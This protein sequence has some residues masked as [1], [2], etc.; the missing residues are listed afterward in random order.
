MDLS[1][2]AR[3]LRYANTRL[4]TISV[5]VDHEAGEVCFG[6]GFSGEPPMRVETHMDM[7]RT[8][9]EVAQLLLEDL[10]PREGE[11]LFLLVNRLRLTTYADSFIIANLVTRALEKHCPVTQLRVAAFSNI[12]DKYGF[13]FSILC[14]DGPT[15]KLMDTFIAT[16]SFTI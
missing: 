15:A 13:D 2:A 9:E 6:P 4:G 3:L 7:E 12:T 1:E 16:D 14:M 10:H 8:A 5:H 11:T